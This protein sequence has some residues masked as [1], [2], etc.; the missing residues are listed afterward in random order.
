L[1]EIGKALGLL[2]IGEKGSASREV[3]PVEVIPIP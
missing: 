2:G 3:A 1:I